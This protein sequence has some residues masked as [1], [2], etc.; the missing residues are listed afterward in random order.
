MTYNP[1]VLRSSLRANF[2]K[3]II[4]RADY[5][6][7]ISLDETIDHIKSFLFS[8]GFVN[9]DEKFINEVD[10]DLK[11]PELIETKFYLPL[12]ELKQTK[13][14]RFT[15]E[16]FAS[17]NRT[18]EFTIEVSKYFAIFDINPA[19][20]RPFEYYADIFSSLVLLIKNYNEFFKA[21]RIGIR[22]INT[23]FFYDLTKIPEYFNKQ[24]YVPPFF[25]LK[26]RFDDLEFTKSEG[27]DSFNYKDVNFN[28]IRYMD[29]GL[30]GE[31]EAYQTILDIDGYTKNDDALTGDLLSNEKL[32]SRMQHINELLFE[33]FINCLTST[34][35][36]DLVDGRITYDDVI[37]VEPNE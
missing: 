20:Y 36:N 18:P 16:T 4:V 33:L 31:R 37:G 6:G 17:D 5:K 8:K 11:D 3:K 24:Y 15:T 21:L 13:S 35:I 23:L 12:K 30:L 19:S 34:F 1:Q 32:K 25:S 9:L 22:K 28:Y 26:N 2:L 7:V 29:K 27:V 10:L 14:Y